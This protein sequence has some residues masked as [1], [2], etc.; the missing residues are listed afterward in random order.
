[1]R[2]VGTVHLGDDPFHIT[3]DGKK[4][5]GQFHDTGE[6]VEFDTP[7]ELYRAL[8]AFVKADMP[9][10]EMEWESSV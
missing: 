10:T 7:E 8:I 2:K 6:M 5:Y 4:I 3:T 9:G 1:M